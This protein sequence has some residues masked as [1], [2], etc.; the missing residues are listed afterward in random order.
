MLRPLADHGIRNIIGVDPATN[1]VANIHDPRV[2]IINDYFNEDVARQIV[3]EYGKV[4]MIM[5][6]NVFA[7]IPDIKGITRAV[8]YAL[9]D[10]GVFIFEVHYLG[11]VSYTHLTLPTILLV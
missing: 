5:A 3:S 10:D 1:V 11:T 8:E 6:N 2:K 4:D 9:D 7:H